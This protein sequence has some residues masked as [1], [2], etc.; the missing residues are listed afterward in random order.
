MPG[1][2]QRF[3]GSATQIQ[4]ERTEWGADGSV[5]YMEAHVFDSVG[6]RR[7]VEPYS[8]DMVGP[9]DAPALLLIMVRTDA[10]CREAEA[11]GVPREREQQKQWAGEE[12][13]APTDEDRTDDGHRADGCKD[14]VEN[15]RRP[16]NETE[17][18]LRIDLDCV[19]ADGR[20]AAANTTT[21]DVCGAF[22]LADQ[23]NDMRRVPRR[24]RR[25]EYDVTFRGHHA[26]HVDGVSRCP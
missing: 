20:S 14:R 15:D 2:R 22:A 21:D 25:H 19:P 1:Q 16:G 18:V 12:Q 9:G 5:S 11:Q 17:S 24:W 7:Q 3:S 6:V 23:G 26:Q 8:N 10:V 13:E 4:R